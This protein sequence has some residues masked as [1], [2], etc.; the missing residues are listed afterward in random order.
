MARIGADYLVTG[1]VLGRNGIGLAELAALDARVG[2]E[3]RVLRPLCFRYG[4]ADAQPGEWIDVGVSRDG[5]EAGSGWISEWAE[6]MGIDP[7]DPLG[8]ERRCKLMI[9]GFGERVSNLFDEQGFTLNA[10]R[11]L[12]FMLYYKL[13]PDTKVVLA[14]TEEEK[15]ELQNLYLP[16][17]LRVYPSTP[18][19]PMTLVRADW[20]AKSPVEQQEIIALAARITA[21][22]AGMGH[23]S[24]VPIY[25]RFESDD[26]TTLINARPFPSIGEIAEAPEIEALHLF[27]H[28]PQP[29]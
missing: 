25:Y 4:E 26:E 23:S 9:P 5:E 20:A 3:G 11:L 24:T 12:D 7:R 6:S 29:A 18:Y 8:C 17:D 19:G 28:E 22:H 21:T 16:Q 10:L 2:V 27:D 14:S 15:R 13:P 1:D